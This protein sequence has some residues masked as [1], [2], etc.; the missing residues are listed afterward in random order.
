MPELPEVETIV[1]DLKK[2]QPPILGA[3]FIDVWSDAAK[4][5]KRPKDFEQF[6]KEIKGK[7]I[8][9]IWRRGKNIIFD[10]SDDHSLLVHLKL[11]GHFL[12]GQW[13]KVR[14]K[15]Q[16]QSFKWK[17][18]QKGFLQDPMNRF[19]H[20]IFWL[21]N[22][23]ML[24]LSD[25]RKFAKIELWK[26]K[27]LKNFKELQALGPEPL[28]KEFTLKKFK[29]LLSSNQRR[30]KEVLMDQKMIAGIGNIYSDEIL[31]RAKIYPFKKAGRL[32]NDELKRVYRAIKKVLKKA[33]ELR[34][35]STSDYRDIRGEKGFFDKA[36]K[37]YGQEGRLCRHCHAAI[38]R[39]K[40]GSRSAHFC[41]QCQR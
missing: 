9:K 2:T 11:T 17:P 27:E 33:I 41:P 10:L 24:A 26:N 21:D 3:G 5:V 23:Q 35:T 13:K 8:E 7:R 40:M 32:S 16:K 34:G 14:A 37:V 1:R 19:L 31:W 12:Y 22:N 38:K 20:L 15:E 29:S 18:L 30:I 39:K 36:L 6:K 25:M 28:E 4:I